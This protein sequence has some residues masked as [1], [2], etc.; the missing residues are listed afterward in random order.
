MRNSEA[1]VMEG[2]KVGGWWQ[3][4][5]WSSFG[6]EGDEAAAVVAMAAAVGCV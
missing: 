2:T 5:A 1:V 3:N 4:V 6:K